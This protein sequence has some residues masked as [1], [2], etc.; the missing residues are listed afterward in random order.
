MNPTSKPAM[1]LLALRAPVLSSALDSVPFVLSPGSG[2]PE[3]LRPAS[4]PS[5]RSVPMHRRQWLKNTTTAAGLFGLP[6]LLSGRLGSAAQPA[7]AGG[8]RNLPPLKI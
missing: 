3:L 8:G 2:R 4:H 1:P 5:T 6:L 7:P